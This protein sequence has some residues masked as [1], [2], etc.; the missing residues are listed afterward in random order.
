MLLLEWDDEKARR[1]LQKHG[2]S[3]EEAATVFGDRLSVTIGDPDHSHPSDE[4]FITMGLSHRGRILVIAHRD[5]ADTVRII[6][7]RLA[8]NR[9][10]NQYETEL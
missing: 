8:T 7:A 5:D 3:F 4:R 10:R 2:V 9:E 1:N 6:S